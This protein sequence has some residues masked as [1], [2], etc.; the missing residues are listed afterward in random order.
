MMGNDGE[1][2]HPGHGHPLCPLNMWTQ[3]SGPPTLSSPRSP[4]FFSV[5]GRCDLFW[6]ATRPQLVP[7]G[8]YMTPPGL[9]HSQIQ[10]IS[11]HF[12]PFCCYLPCARAWICR[13]EEEILVSWEYLTPAL[14]NTWC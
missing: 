8:W 6:G 7:G 13:V 12:D 3:V 10:G 9:L 4:L 14:I 1:P 5:P 2:Q 11:A